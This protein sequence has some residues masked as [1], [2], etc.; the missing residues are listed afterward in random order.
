MSINLLFFAI[1]FTFVTTTFA[2]EN[3]PIIK[4][5]SPFVNVKDGDVLFNEEWIIGEG[6]PTKPEVYIPL[7]SNENKQITFATDIDSI[8]FD[9]KSNGKYSFIIEFKNEKV[10]TEINRSEKLTPTLRKG[11]TFSKNC[12]NCADK[13]NIIPFTINPNDNGIRIQGK[14]NDSEILDLVFDTGAKFVYVSNSK[15][16]KKIKVSIDGKIQDVGS[17]GISIEDKSAGNRLNIANLNWKNLEMVSTD[18]GEPDGIIG[19]NVFENNPI[20]INYDTKI[21]TI[22]DSTATISKDFSKHKMEIFNGSPFI[23]ATLIIGDK[24]VTDWFLFDSGFNRSLYLSNRLAAKNQIIGTMRRIGKGTFSSSAGNK[25]AIE[26]VVLPKIRIGNYEIEQIPTSM[27]VTASEE[28]PHNDILGNELLKGFN[29][30]LDFKNKNIYLKPNNLS[31]FTRLSLKETPRMQYSLDDPVLYDTIIRLD[32]EFF[33]NYNTCDK[34]LDKYAAF[35]SEN[36]EFY[37][38]QGGLMTSKQGIIDATKRNICGKVTRELVKDSIEVYPIKDYGAVEIGLHKFHNN[39]EPPNTPSKIGRFM[40][41]WRNQNNEWKIT[42][43][44]SLH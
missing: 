11:I 25:I 41:I 24:Q 15:P 40:I 39:A 13:P 21:M 44:V 31:S 28:I 38:D 9:T 2:Q 16:D 19:W 20:E 34:N 3:F 30:V 8:T 33:N 35:F 26:N 12:Q 37:H 36:I 1:I 10:F 22:H 43:V 42:R 5:N 4:A 17:D 6:T 7:K 23:E 29:V 27:N 18:L 32:G 14:I